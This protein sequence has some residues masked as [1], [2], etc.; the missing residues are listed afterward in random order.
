MESM[1]KDQIALMDLKA[2]LPA[3]GLSSSNRAI[4][5]CILCEW[6]RRK[7][8]T[9][10]RLRTFGNLKENYDNFCR[11]GQPLKRAQDYMNVINPSLINGEDED[12]VMDIVNCPELH[13]MEGI[14]NY[15]I[16]ELERSF[17]IEEMENFYSKIAIVKSGQQG[18]KFA[19]PPCMKILENSDY[20]ASEQALSSGYL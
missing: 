10:A 5:C 4:H 15:L 1:N 11:D 9:K 8:Y 20:L 18:G 2:S 13:I 7:P 19:G 3:L 17:G 6:D 16:S 14:V 12:L